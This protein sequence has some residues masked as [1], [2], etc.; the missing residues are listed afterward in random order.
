MTA[1]AMAIAALLGPA[2][3]QTGRSAGAS[4]G[5]Q[6]NAR[7][8]IVI[9]AMQ[10]RNH[11]ARADRLAERLARTTGMKP[12]R[13]VDEGSRSVVYFGTY[14]NPESSGA[15]NDLSKLRRLAAQGRVPSD[16]LMLS[17]IG[18][19]ASGD[20][21]HDL[22]N[23][24]HEDAVYT[25]Q[26]AMFDAEH[27]SDFRQAA[28]DLARQYRDEGHEAYFFHGPRQSLVTIGVFT[29]AAAR[30]AQSGPNRGQS[31]YHRRIRREYQSKFPHLRVNGE[32]APLPGNADA[33]TPT[34][35]VRIPK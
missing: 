18:P 28:E 24:T 22:R 25:L 27:G 32:K 17:P 30:V 4:A 23:V 11:N 2:G 9:T 5:G 8:G 6:G 35:L 7:W 15:H 26:V 21:P 16:A 12:F 14:D 1:M 34:F 13:A 10:G 3:C 19:S 29:H 20:N 33:Y 31:V